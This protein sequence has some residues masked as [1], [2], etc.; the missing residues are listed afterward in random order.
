MTWSND[1]NTFT[2]ELCRFLYALKCLN[3]ALKYS[4]ISNNYKEFP[5]HKKDIK[6]IKYSF[7]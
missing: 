4:D 7:V 3:K 1:P 2:T 5:N 6:K